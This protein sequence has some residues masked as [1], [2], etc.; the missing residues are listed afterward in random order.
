MVPLEINWQYCYK[1]S[2]NITRIV[3]AVL[4]GYG[5]DDCFP[6]VIALRFLIFDG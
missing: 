6:L 2:K 3:G 1:A 4:A 5:L